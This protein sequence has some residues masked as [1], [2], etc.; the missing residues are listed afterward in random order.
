MK[1]D[2]LIIG[3]GL[4]GLACA[5]TLTDHGVQNTVLEAID[6]VGGRIWVSLLFCCN[7]MGPEIP[8]ALV[9]DFVIRCHML[10]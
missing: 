8:T 4:A 10:K 1:P 5:M 9:P 3:G 6:G 2:V 7:G